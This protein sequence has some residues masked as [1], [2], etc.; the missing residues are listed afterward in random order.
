MIPL[1]DV[2]TPFMGLV[3]LQLVVVN[4]VVAPIESLVLRR[5]FRKS[6]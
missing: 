5:F 4:L 1:A 3:G 2:I 6:R